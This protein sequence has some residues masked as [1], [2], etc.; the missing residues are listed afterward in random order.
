MISTT[1]FGIILGFVAILGSFFW[2]GGSPETLFLLPAITIVIGGTLAAGI[3][4]TSFQVFARLPVLLRITISPKQY[5]WMALLDKI[6]L[7]SS[8]ARKSGILTLEESVNK[9]E[10]PFMRKMFLVMIDGIDNQNLLNIAEF[11]LS[12]I[13]ERHFENI[14]FLNK[15]GGYSPTMGIIGTVMGLIATF[16][17]AGSDPN[18]LIHHIASAFIATLWGIFMANIVWLPL[19]D[20]L[21]YLHDAEMKL[22]NFIL[23]GISAIQ[24]GDTPS[25][26]MMKLAAAFPASEQEGI[27]KRLKKIKSNELEEKRLHENQINH[28]NQPMKVKVS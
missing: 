1:L 8:Q 22:N 6:I 14:S 4:G 28:Q 17:A 18:V 3:T 10:H 5:N 23:N 20:K 24:I 15:L 9:I 11:E 2:E 27:M 12:S 21:R 19:A 16:A 26:I 25:V 7:L 13:T